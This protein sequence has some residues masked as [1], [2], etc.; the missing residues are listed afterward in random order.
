MSKAAS[1]FVFKFIKLLLVAISRFYGGNTQ[2]C[3]IINAP[4]VRR[5]LQ[6]PLAPTAPPSPPH[7]Q[8]RASTPT[9]LIRSA[10]LA[11]GVPAA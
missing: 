5:R 2:K 9:R 1:P 4:L 3:I 11:A 6:L 7:V 8:R 10:C